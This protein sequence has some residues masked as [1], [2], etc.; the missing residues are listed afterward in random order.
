[1]MSGEIV[2]NENHIISVTRLPHGRGV[3]EVL[4]PSDLDGAHT[5]EKS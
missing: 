3:Y 4:P 2:E 1:M 5:A